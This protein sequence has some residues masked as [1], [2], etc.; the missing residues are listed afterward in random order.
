MGKSFKIQKAY[1]KQES[2][3]GAGVSGDFSGATGGR[4]WNASD[5]PIELSAVTQQ[6]SPVQFTIGSMTE[7]TPP[8]EATLEDITFTLKQVVAGASLNVSDEYDEDNLDLLLESAIGPVDYAANND[9]AEAASTATVIKSTA[10]PFDAG[11]LVMINGEVRLVSTYVSPDLTITLPLSAA[12]SA[13]DDMFNVGKY[14]SAGD[15]ES[16]AFGMTHTATNTDYLINGCFCEEPKLSTFNNS[17]VVTIDLPFR[18]QNAS[19]GSGLVT[20]ASANEVENDAVSCKAGG[21]CQM[22]KSDGTSLLTLNVKEAEIGI[23]TKN[24]PVPAFTA[25]NGIA[26]FVKVPTDGQGSLR[27]VLWDSDDA[28][29]EL[30]VALIG[31]TTEIN[32]QMGTERGKVVGC[33]FP[34]AAI[35]EKEPRVVDMDGVLGIE[36]MFRTAAG[37]IYRA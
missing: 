32:V 21:K 31:T 37:Y 28:T 34:E 19:V 15:S 36:V 9:Q 12:P 5:G 17:D 1:F 26:G 30:L 7:I 10:G 4:T 18:G 27:L 20:V 23:G 16:L 14:D 11:D 8:A 3:F 35:M 33:Y 29:R 22:L 25:K 13:A 6:L 24:I 2:T